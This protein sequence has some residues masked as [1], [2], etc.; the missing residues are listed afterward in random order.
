MGSKEIIVGHGHHRMLVETAYDRI[1]ATMCDEN[2]DWFASM[3]RKAWEDMPQ[4]VQPKEI[5]AL[6]SLLHCRRQQLIRMAASR[7]GTLK[8]DDT[9]EWVCTSTIAEI[10]KDTIVQ[11]YYHIISTGEKRE[12]GE[13]QLR[14]LHDDYE[15]VMEINVAKEERHEL[16]LVL[17]RDMTLP[18]METKGPNKYGGDQIEDV[19]V[20][21]RK[22][23]Y[24]DQVPEN[25]S[26]S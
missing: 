9:Y 5:L 15:I 20:P 21:Y 2:I 8:L 4:Q 10:D 3:I 11:G 22:E 6:E 23:N 26:P 18:P 17:E 13:L 7:G 24:M 12:Y 14:K 19:I 25:T 1:L 16:P